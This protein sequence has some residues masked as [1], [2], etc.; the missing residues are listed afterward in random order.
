[1]PIWINLN[2]A[3]FHTSLV[4]YSKVKLYKLKYQCCIFLLLGYCKRVIPQ[5][6]RLCSSILFVKSS[7]IIRTEWPLKDRWKT[8]FVE[9]VNFLLYSSSAKHRK[10][11]ATIVLGLNKELNITFFVE[12]SHKPCDCDKGM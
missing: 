12:I 2:M 4:A 9:S 1:M 10:L 5:L 11:G 7:F 8:S 3:N 6:W